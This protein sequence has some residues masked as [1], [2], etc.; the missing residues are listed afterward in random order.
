MLFKNNLMPKSHLFNE[1]GNVKTISLPKTSRQVFELVDFKVWSVA[2]FLNYL[3][4]QG[5]LLNLN[6]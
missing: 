2:N 1:W 5:Q 4:K 6:C 3:E